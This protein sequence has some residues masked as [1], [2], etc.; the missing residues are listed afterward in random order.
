MRQFALPQNKTVQCEC[1]SGVFNSVENQRCKNAAKRIAMLLFCFV[2]ILVQMHLTKRMV[3]SPSWL[4]TVF[5]PG[6]FKVPGLTIGS[7]GGASL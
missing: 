2:V 6:R 5:Y 7:A 4:K 1:T 3:L